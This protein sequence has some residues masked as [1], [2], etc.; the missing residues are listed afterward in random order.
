MSDPDIT[1]TNIHDQVDIVVVKERVVIK[2]P[3][4]LMGVDY[5]FEEKLVVNTLFVDR[6]AAERYDVLREPFTVD[7][8][9]FLRR[10]HDVLPSHIY[11]ALQ[12]EENK[13]KLLNILRDGRR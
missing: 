4:T 6:T 10:Y 9:I 7:F 11:L 8:K 2:T 13:F 12:C 3:T 1:I 5:K